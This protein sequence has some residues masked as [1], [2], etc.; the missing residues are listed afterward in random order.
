[1]SL[2]HITGRD[3]N[4]ALNGVVVCNE[5]HSHY[6]HSKDEEKRLFAKNLSILNSMK[7]TINDKDEEFMADH[8]Y[9][10]INN[11]YLDLYGI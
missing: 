6:G 5:C 11:P 8:P 7:Y 3:S 2:H 1:M 10:I 9:L 4:S